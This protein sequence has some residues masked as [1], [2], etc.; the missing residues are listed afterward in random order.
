MTRR[1]SLAAVVCGVVLASAA[2]YPRTQAEA[3]QQGSAVAS[4][5]RPAQSGSE[6]MRSV[7][8]GRRSNGGTADRLSV[9]AEGTAWHQK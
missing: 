2:A 8:G 3:R 4:D 1:V 9:R 5:R 6:A 7:S